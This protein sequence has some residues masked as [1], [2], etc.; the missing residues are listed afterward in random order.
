MKR[1]PHG[2]R[3]WHVGLVHCLV[4]VLV[5]CADAYGDAKLDQAR[6]KYDQRAELFSLEYDEAL[7][8]QAVK[9]QSTLSGAVSFYQARG[10]LEEVLKYKGELDRFSQSGSLG[11]NDVVIAPA[12][13]A[14]IQRG[15]LLDEAKLAQERD[16]KI[17]KLATGYL[18]GLEK[19]KMALTKQSRLDDAI[20][21][22]KEQ[23]RI[24]ASSSFVAAKV[25]AARPDSRPSKSPR[26]SVSDAD[27]S[28][29]I[30][31][32]KRGV[33]PPR[34]QIWLF[35]MKNGFPLRGAK[36]FVIS[37]DG[38]ES[39]EKTTDGSGK[40]SYTTKTGNSFKVVVVADGFSA[41]EIDDV[42][43]GAAFRFNLVPGKS[44][45]RY[46]V[47]S[48][49]SFKW[50]E[51]G[52]IRI[53]SWSSS[54][55]TRG[56]SFYGSTGMKFKTSRYSTSYSSSYVSIRPEDTCEVM[57]DDIHY[58]FTVKTLGTDKFLI[59]YENKED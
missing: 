30:D 37:E 40:I 43:A 46:L 51:L 28:D 55:G 10:E 27:P 18:A 56:P 29:P 57:K 42:H 3:C 39:T 14:Q 6:A 36:F 11:G 9:Y 54:D 33:R 26:N 45:A 8:K 22:A 25:A 52:D 12:K 38:T 53:S 16:A 7:A 35:A 5:G 4:F 34:D 48:G 47:A 2:N 44:G 20:L 21:Y 58:V 15:F 31:L 13:L 50:P 24:R 49:R 59:R 1:V 17:A 41:Q 23:E 32:T 19:M